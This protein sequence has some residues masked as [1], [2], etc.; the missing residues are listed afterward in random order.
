MARRDTFKTNFA[1]GELSEDI[2]SRTDTEQ[3]LAG[4]RKLRNYRSLLGGGVERRPGFRRLVQVA[5]NAKV[6]PFEI[7]AATRYWLVFSD[8]AMEAFL[9]DGTASGSLS[10]QPW[11]GTTWNEF[12]WAQSGARLYVTHPTFGIYVVERT[13]AST[14][15]STAFAFTEIA[16]D[17][18]QPYYKLAPSAVTLDSSGYTGSVTLTTS[19]DWW[20]AGHVGNWIRYLGAQIEITAVTNGT[21]A[22]GTVRQLLPPSQDLT[23]TSSAGFTVGQLVEGSTTGAKGVVRNIPAGT[24]LSV[25]I[26]EGR[27]RFEV[28]DII[29]PTAITACSAVG[30]LGSPL[31]VQDWDEEVLSALWGWPRT[32]TIHDNRLI[33]GGLPQIP[34][35]LMGSRVGEY[36]DFDV[37]DAGDADGFFEIMGEAP[38]QRI[39]DLISQEQLLIMT[40]KGPFYVP[41]TVAN[42]FRPTAISFSKFGGHWESTAPLGEFD[43]GVIVTAGSLVYK[44]RPTGDQLKM[45]EEDEVSVFSWHLLKDVVDTAF[46]DPIGDRPERY[47]FFVNDDGTMAV[48]MLMERQNFRSFVPWDTQGGFKSVATNRGDVAVIVRRNVAGTNEHWLEVLELGLLLDGATQYASLAA[49]AD[50]KYSGDPVH[51]M[52]GR[53]WFGKQTAAADGSVTVDTDWSGPFEVG[54]NFTTELETLPPVLEDQ[55]GSRQGDTARITR[56]LVHVQSSMR[57]STNGYELSAYHVGDDANLEPPLR[58]QPTEFRF[59]GWVTEPTIRITQPQPGYLKVGAIQSTVIW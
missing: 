20:V 3:Y 25:A 11:T 46:S 17:R 42:P 23:V 14:W 19:A 52:G 22:T 31:P 41:Q 6:I 59:F 44:L 56:A 2:Y 16:G 49:T 29:G 27:T 21:T 12:K 8:G 47:G 51:V 54:F 28:E 9:I 53:F 32:L 38:A 1:A 7:D 10:S 40:D 45:W 55:S 48:M 58:T 5:G 37:G 57:F 50:G 13:G 43:N 15:T 30:D 34:G 4:A 35:A 24:T 36:T 33:F 26:T 39:V 18:K